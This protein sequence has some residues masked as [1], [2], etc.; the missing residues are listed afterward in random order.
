MGEGSVGNSIWEPGVLLPPLPN[1]VELVAGY[2]ESV[3]QVEVVKPVRKIQTPS[4]KTVIDFGQNLVGCVRS[5]NTK[6]P[7][8]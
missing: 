5:K 7:K 1:S 4:N 6:G 8:G 3:R 2:G